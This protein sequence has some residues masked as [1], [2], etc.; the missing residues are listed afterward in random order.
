MWFHFANIAMVPSGERGGFLR[1][2]LDIARTRLQIRLRALS[3]RFERGGPKKLQRGY[4]HLL[5]KKVNDQAAFQYVPKVYSGRV[6]VIMPKRYF[7]GLRSPTFGWGGLVHEG[8]EVHEVPEYPKGMLVE[9]FCRS[10]AGIV[11]RCL[12][13][14]SVTELAAK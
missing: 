2:K 10:L 5:I 13:D 9:P 12:A 8:P 4:P 7:A 11:K 14:V 1:E 6:A 3:Y